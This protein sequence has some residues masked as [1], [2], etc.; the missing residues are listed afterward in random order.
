[1][2]NRHKRKKQ[3]ERSKKR[4]GPASGPSKQENA[5]FSLMVK[6][7]YKFIQTV[8][9]LAV[10]ISLP[11]GQYPPA[12]LKKKE[13]LDRFWKPSSST[14]EVQAKF[15]DLSKTYMDGAINIMKDH[16][17]TTSTDLASKLK[18]NTLDKDSFSK[19][20]NIATTW[21]KK[22]YRQKLSEN[23]L[24]EFD[25]QC[26]EINN[27]KTRETTPLASTSNQPSTE[28][29][30]DKRAPVKPSVSHVNTPLASN[31]SETPKRKRETTPPN[32]PSSPSGEHGELETNSPS[33]KSPPTK[34]SRTSTARQSP[35]GPKK[36]FKPYRD[37]G[38]KHSWTLPLIKHSTVII[39]DSNLNRIT[40][41]HSPLMHICSFPGAIFSN[42]KNLLQRCTPYV[43]VKDVVISLG[44]NERGNKVKQTSMPMLKKLISEAKRAFPNAK[45][46]MAKLQWNSA[47]LLPAQNQALADL[48]KYMSEL[49]DVNILPSLSTNLFKIDTG[50]RYGIH[51][52]K[53]CANHMLDNWASHL[54]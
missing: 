13:E 38:P 9:H 40:K 37:E 2:A 52:T 6:L 47:K 14:D 8:H 43:G 41:S 10:L 16:Y 24:K 25:K 27:Q 1:M 36:S 34:H 39:G 29:K 46:H 54:N 22:N 28:H 15:R 18:L 35:R 51:W 7:M 30:A 44:I 49:P 26:D 31:L 33:V 21:A 11:D 32:S 3:G 50:D 48:D 23:T 12:L 42:V 53:E 19:A 45:I 5:A 17:K 20:K 4:Q